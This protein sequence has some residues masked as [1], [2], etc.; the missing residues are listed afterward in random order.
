MRF[1]LL[2]TITTIALVWLAASSMLLLVRLAPG[3]AP[4]NWKPGMPLEEVAR[5]RARLGLDQPWVTYYGEWIGRAVRLD[6]GAST[7]Y[8][9]PVVDLVAERAMN[10]ALLA[11]SALFVATVI[12]LPLGVIAGSGRPAPVAAGIRFLSTLFLS[13]PPLLTSL[14]LAWFAARTGW[15]PIGGMRDVNAEQFDAI[16]RLRDVIWHLALPMTALALPLAATFERLQADAIE[17]VRAEP[18]VVAAL[19]RGVPAWRVL[20]RDLWRLALG[21]VVALYGLA[22]G[23]LLSGA[24]AVEFVSSWPGLGRLMF[25]ALGTRDLPLAAG[26]A[27]AA[28]LFLGVW[29]MLSDLALRLVDPRLREAD[30][31]ERHEAV[32]AETALP[33]PQPW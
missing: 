16:G 24:L 5:E 8:Q 2:R 7:R 27:A 28:A 20:W 17:T 9:R 31:R 21:P 25:E 13:A 22:A 3:W 32:S 33:E 18:F 23:H 11:L 29:T 6:F 26:C 15:F 14:I 1:L 4:D 10:T 12:G 30:S 19:A